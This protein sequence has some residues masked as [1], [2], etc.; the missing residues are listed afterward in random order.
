M[1]RKGKRED[2]AQRFTIKKFKF[3]AASVLIGTVFA[4]F[5]GA[6]QAETETSVAEGTM[7][8]TLVSE[9][10]VSSTEV[11][12]VETPVVAEEVVS[13]PVASSEETVASSEVATSSEEVSEESKLE[14]STSSSEET[15]KET[16]AE[17]TTTAISAS[18]STSA[19]VTTPS[20][21]V[22]T[23][24]KVTYTD[25]ETGVV[26]ANGRSKSTATTTSLPVEETD[27]VTFEVTEKANM[28]LPEL[29]GYK[30]AA[31]QAEVQVAIIT[32][33]DRNSRFI[34]FNV[35]K[36][37]VA[38]AGGNNDNETES[39]GFRAVIMPDNETDVDEVQDK[40]NFEELNKFSNKDGIVYVLNGDTG[41]IVEVDT[42]A[43]T[44]YYITSGMSQAAAGYDSLEA[45]GQKYAA[46]FKEDTELTVN[47]VAFNGLGV[48]DDGTTLYMYMTADFSSNSRYQFYEKDRGVPLAIL[49]MTAESRTWEVV[50]DYK[51]WD[52]ANYP[53][54]NM[55]SYTMGAIDPTTGIYYIAT[56][57]N[58]FN[59]NF[60]EVL[61]ATNEEANAQKDQRDIVLRFWSYNPENSEFRNIGYIKTNANQYNGT[62]GHTTNGDIA[63]TDE[64][65]M[66]IILRPTGAGNLA[67]TG[68]SLQYIVESD[69][70]SAAARTGTKYT[71][72]EGTLSAPF[73][74]AGLTNGTG[75]DSDGV[76]YYSTSRST[77]GKIV[78]NGDGTFT[79]TD[80]IYTSSTTSTGLWSDLAA[81]TYRAKGT[82]RI[83]YQDTEGNKISEN[84][85][86]VGKRGENYDATVPEV[87]P[88]EITTTDGK[89]YRIVRSEGTEIGK[90]KS[91]VI[92]VTHIYQE[93]KGSVV[94]NYVDESNTVLQESVTDTEETSTG[95]S[96]DTTDNKPTRLTKDGKTYELVRTEGN[97]TGTVT[98]GRTEV[99]Y[100]YREVKG[101]VVVNYVDE[102]NTVLQESVTDTE[103]TSTGTSYDTTDNKPTTLTKDGKTYEL[104]RT[105][106]NET[107]TVTEGRTEVTY[108]YREVKGSVVVNYVDESNTV[109]QEP[110][111]DTEEASTGT[112]YD[113]T[114]NKLTRLTKDGKTY[115]L[116]RTEGDE[117]GTVT[118][119]RTEVTY[120]YREV[121]GSVVVNYVDESNTV[122]QEPVTDTEEA[123]TGTSYDTTDNK[124]T[125][126][127]KDGKTYELVRTEGNETGTVTEGR[128]DVTYVY[129]EVVSPTPTG[130]VVVNYVDES[131]TVLQEP[132]TDT[133]EASTGTS[134]DTTDN[135]PTTLTKDGK[136][137]ELVRTE[138]DETG[139]VT[140]GR[141]EVTYVYREVVSPVKTSTTT[142]FVDEN[143]TP[144]LPSEEGSQP[145]KDISGYKLV[146]STTDEKGNVVHTYRKVVKTTTSFV[147]ESGTPLLP[148]EEGSQPSK[149]ISGYKL[150]SSTTDEKGNV[151]HTYRKVVKTTTSFVD[152]S[153]TPL[154]PSEEG[155]Q[156]SQAISEYKLVS[157]TT[158]E[159]G[160]VVHTYRK[161]VKTTTS[162]VDESGTP[163][164]PSEEGNQPS[165]DIS[166]YKLVSSITDEKGNVVHTYRKVVKT[167][168]SFVDE[169]GTPLLPSEEGSQP[170]QDISGYKL[171]SSTTDEKGNVIHTYRKVVKKEE[172]SVP[173][174]SSPKASAKPTKSSE[175]KP[176][177]ATKTENRLEVLPNTGT[178][179]TATVS[180]LGVGMILTALGLAGKRRRK[181][182]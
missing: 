100:V 170:S 93:V 15:V 127:T 80:A 138:G 57:E 77:I 134:Y 61:P 27:K 132:V 23:T 22:A 97:E 147:D 25:V 168:T 92:E 45:L 90:L 88:Q 26:I 135:K 166:G 85:K 52:T 89:T 58:T 137:Y 151:V 54:A 79:A 75:I 14:T 106:G 66:V 121:K 10:E 69:V 152:E 18:T 154:L 28:S 143:G 109:L 160:N 43:G 108:V 181:E 115:E 31:G 32:Y 11:S 105:E 113:T 131:N 159:K 70:I 174:P 81:V 46:Q 163:L 118:E 158:D 35:V 101:S 3:G 78:D 37:D 95:T 172:P 112:S 33:G 7:S 8:T 24:Y 119:G 74:V 178:E 171:V 5:A 167:T 34:N 129:R 49:K 91:E 153:G 141:T 17:A 177:P 179:N 144:L 42:T 39:A 133:E 60:S 102:S 21:V 84:N 99:T 71:K 9:T 30:L 1:F 48:T 117:T 13:E 120:V 126:L 111:T 29:T 175:V 107:G 146:G 140:E 59:R 12:T 44:E 150:V 148:S 123:S 165:K 47:G 155:S 124:P 114:D 96:Y 40:G 62:D 125:R 38:A 104:V 53:N 76:V 169:S 173:T 64:G 72:I 164:L 63:F 145:S 4:V 149:D 82:V 176:A 161:V 87:K 36:E 139:T 128:T 41:E 86:I 116:V 110:V 56:A 16:K 6:A 122:L 2:T 55:P 50:S 103:E 156:P 162:F 94:V 142:S 136:T 65:K 182:N 67:K 83:F 157:S 180:A 130:S 73:A 98:E 20:R 19:S 68:E 51:Q